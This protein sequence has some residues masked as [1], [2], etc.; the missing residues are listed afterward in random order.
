[1]PPLNCFLVHMKPSPERHRYAIMVH[2]GLGQFPDLLVVP[3]PPFCSC[4]MW[5]LTSCIASHSNNPSTSKSSHHSFPQ[6]HP[7]F[8]PPWALTLLPHNQNLPYCQN[9]QKLTSR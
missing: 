3:R 7:F 1:M 6:S 4:S 2:T 8:N 5:Y 9:I